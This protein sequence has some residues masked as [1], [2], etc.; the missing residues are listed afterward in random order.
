MNEWLII[1]AF[2]CAWFVIKL[3]GEQGFFV[4]LSM[5]TVRAMLRMAKV[6]R[7]EK[8]YDLGSGDGRTVIEAARMGAIGV[9][10][11][12]SIPVHMLAKIRL[13]L[14]GA[15]GVTLMRKDLFKIKLDD[16]D[17]VTFY[18]TPKL[19]KMLGPKFRRELKKGT[20]VVS[21]AHEIPGWAPVEKIKTGHFWTYLYKL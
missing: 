19:A 7:G 14:S 8:L 20:R 16:A 13:A 5:G 17:V 11:E 15:R 4:P 9:G 18:L 12:Y 2:F 6:K 10:I 3:R 21:A 1:P